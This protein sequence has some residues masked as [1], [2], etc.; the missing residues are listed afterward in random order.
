MFKITFNLLD[1][2]K[3]HFLIVSTLIE[4][5]QSLVK[6]LSNNIHKATIF[7]KS[8]LNPLRKAL[9]LTYKIIMMLLLKSKIKLIKV[10]TLDA[11]ALPNPMQFL[12][13][14]VYSPPKPLKAKLFIK[15]T[16]IRKLN[17]NNHKNKSS[18]PQKIFLKPAES[19]IP[20]SSLELLMA[21]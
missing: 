16:I 13:M 8:Q 2:L 1:K 5:I 20:K 21:K 11:A 7:S 12:K 18:L 19:Q 9:K 17:N 15:I 3:N 10:T 4:I 14:L 6:A